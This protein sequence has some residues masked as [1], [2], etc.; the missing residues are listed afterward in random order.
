MVLLEKMELPLGLLVSVDPEVQ[1]WGPTQITGAC[2]PSCNAAG[3]RAIGAQPGLLPWSPRR[4]ALSDRP[5][6]GDVILSPF[7]GSCAQLNSLEGNAEDFDGWSHLLL[8]GRGTAGWGRGAGRSQVL[9]QAVGVLQVGTGEG[10][11]GRGVAYTP[12]RCLD[13]GASAAVLRAHVHGQLQ[14][15]GVGTRV[16]GRGTTGSHLPC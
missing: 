13:T 1:S 14:I 10:R 7:S 6:L 5:P 3:D 8:R 9:L 11:R 16:G 4:Q 2:W 15:S 12:R